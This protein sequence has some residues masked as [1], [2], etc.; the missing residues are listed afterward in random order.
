MFIKLNK[1]MSKYILYFNYE[2]FKNNN[3]N[4]DNNEI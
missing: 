4:N 1:K 3:N 2:M